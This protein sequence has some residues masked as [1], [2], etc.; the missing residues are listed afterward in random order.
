M[1]GAA[2]ATLADAYCTKLFISY[3]IRSIAKKAMWFWGWNHAQSERAEKYGITFHAKEGCQYMRG[4]KKFSDDAKAFE[5]PYEA[6]YAEASV[7]PFEK[8]HIMIGFYCEYPGTEGEFSTEG[9][10]RL[11]WNECGIELKAF[12]DAWEAL[13]KMPE[14]TQLLAKIDREEKEPT[15]KEFAE[16]L[17]GL[18]YKDITERV[19]K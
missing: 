15:V 2:K 17:K 4:I 9:E 7:K 6:W 12:N 18:G 19:R 1:N 14:L 11:E 16:M 3:P 13:S 5:I 10:F 8:E